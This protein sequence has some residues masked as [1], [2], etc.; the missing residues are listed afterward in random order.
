MS[1][2]ACLRHFMRKPPLGARFSG[3]LLF[4]HQ[5]L[6]P[7]AHSR[8]HPTGVVGVRPLRPGG[9]DERSRMAKGHYMRESPLGARE[10]RSGANPA[11]APGVK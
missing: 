7:S 10:W 8:I 2:C 1:I 3:A 11:R 6:R 9:L 4:F 5:G